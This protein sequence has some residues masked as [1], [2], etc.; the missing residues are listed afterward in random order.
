MFHSLSY[1]LQFENATLNIYNGGSHK[2]EMLFSIDGFSVTSNGNQLF[3]EFRS[4]DG[5]E[6]E[7]GFSASIFFGI[8]SESLTIFSKLDF[9][10]VMNWDDVVRHIR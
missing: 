2:D 5:H 1:I 6:P 7:K 3:L 4:Y 10:Y 8:R 9:L